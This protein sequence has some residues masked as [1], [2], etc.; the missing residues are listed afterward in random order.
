MMHD[1]IEPESHRRDQL[2]RIQHAL[3]QYDTPLEPRIAQCRGLLDTCHGKRIGHAGVEI[4]RI[5]HIEE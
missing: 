1:Q 4:D 2:T 5:A 3:E